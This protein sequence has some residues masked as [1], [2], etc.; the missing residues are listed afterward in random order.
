MPRNPVLLR[1]V[2]NIPNR[3]GS[4]KEF[5]VR[6]LI[7]TEIYNFFDDHLPFIPR[8][9]ADSDARAAPTSGGTTVGSAHDTH[10]CCR[11]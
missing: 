5:G 10:R 2:K 11:H 7:L 8:E 6:P 3:S 1:V 9:R 4:E